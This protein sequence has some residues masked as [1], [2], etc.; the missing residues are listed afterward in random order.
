MVIMSVYYVLVAQLLVQAIGGM[1]TN[2]WDPQFYYK[3]TVGSMIVEMEI[4]E[5]DLKK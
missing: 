1:V 2:T 3:H 4:K 5:R